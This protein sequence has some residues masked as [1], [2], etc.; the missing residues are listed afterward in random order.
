MWSGQ[1]AYPLE[2]AAME[3]VLRASSRLASGAGATVKAL[4]VRARQ[5]NRGRGE[6]IVWCS[7]GRRGV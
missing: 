4:R 2:V 3:E 1:A 5:V 6:T 7:A